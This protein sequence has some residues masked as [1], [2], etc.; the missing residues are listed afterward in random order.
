MFPDCDSWNYLSHSHLAPLGAF[1]LI[2]ALSTGVLFLRRKSVVFGVLGVSLLFVLTVYLYSLS[3]RLAGNHFLVL[4]L[5]TFAF[6]ILPKKIQTL[7]ILIAAVYL[8]SAAQ[9]LNTNWLTGAA[10]PVNWIDN[11]SVLRWILNAGLLPAGSFYVVV[12]ETAGTF[13]LF[14]KRRALRFIV[15]A[16]F[17]LFHLISIGV[18]GWFFPLMMCLLLLVFVSGGSAPERLKLPRSSAFFVVSFLSLQV[19]PSVFARESSLAGVGRLMKL[20]MYTSQTS[21]ESKWIA[22]YVSHSSAINL[23]PGLQ[24]KSKRIRSKCEPYVIFVAGKAECKRLQKDKDFL[25]LR[26]SLNLKD[27]ASQPPQNAFHEV[28]SEFNLCDESIKFKASFPGTWPDPNFESPSRRTAF[29]EFSLGNSLEHNGH[30]AAAPTAQDLSDWKFSLSKVNTDHWKLMAFDSRQIVR[31]YHQDDNL[32]PASQGSPLLSEG[33]LYW[34]GSEE[35]LSFDSTAGGVLW[36]AKVEK[37][38]VISIALTQYQGKEA[39]KVEIYNDQG[40]PTRSAYLDP[41]SGKGL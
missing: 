38:K 30:L 22:D 13:F 40:N 28:R 10:I 5:V 6:L 12:L 8:V 19:L 11:D 18:V 39:L 37:G 14:S 25:R 3:Y 23:D 9:K 20:D 27:S 29:L 32:S 21:C 15:V 1:Y 26:W 34:A 35:I 16:Q 33:R 7:Q 2:I 31:W 41:I 24:F 17:F 36:L 4:F